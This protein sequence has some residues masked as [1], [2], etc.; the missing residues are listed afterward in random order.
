M[1]KRFTNL[2]ILIFELFFFL[3]QP[4]AQVKAETRNWFPPLNTPNEKAEFLFQVMEEIPNIF[5][6]S[7]IFHFD[8]MNLLEHLV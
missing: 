2:V 3:L 5:E 4:Y 6:T 7:N 8:L 1:K